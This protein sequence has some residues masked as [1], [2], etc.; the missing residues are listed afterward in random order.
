[1]SL[2]LYR[3]LVV[4][5]IADLGEYELR[6]LLRVA[7]RLAMGRTQY[8]ELDLA[9]DRRNWDD[10]ARAEVLDLAVY[11]AMALERPR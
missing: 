11:V 1:M 2:D 8:G 7:D 9:R 10:E 5:R 6:V 3:S 4:T